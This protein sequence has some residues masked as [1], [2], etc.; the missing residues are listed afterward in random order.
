MIAIVNIGPF[1]D[2]DPLGLRRYEVRINDQVLAE[3]SHRRGDG[4]AECLRRAS[5]AVATK[6]LKAIG[7]FGL[8]YDFKN[9]VFDDLT[10]S[11]TE[12]PAPD[13]PDESP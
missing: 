6:R 4:L 8:G 13:R 7:R 2:P 12:P 11:S 5:Y 10:E 9:L 1:D 3:F